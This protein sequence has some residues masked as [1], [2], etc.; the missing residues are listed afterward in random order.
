MT[1]SRADQIATFKQSIS[2]LE[3][4]QRALGVDLSASITPLRATL[5]QLESAETTTSISDRSGGIDISA[6]TVVA[7]GDVV[8]RDRIESST[9]TAAT[10]TGLGAVAQGARAQAAGANSIVIGGN[11]TGNVIV[12]PEKTIETAVPRQAPKPGH[13]Y[14]PRENDEG[15]VRKALLDPDDTRP[16][17]VLYGPPSNGKSALAGAVVSGLED[18]AFPDGV[19]WGNLAARSLKDVLWQFAATLDARWL[20]AN[21]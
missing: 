15:Q 14:V 3:E 17:T 21:Q 5:T 20:Q 7:H 10:N 9:V 11:V 4:Q 6:E 19:L 12:Q 13:D 1:D 16:V 2:D 8:G 18:G